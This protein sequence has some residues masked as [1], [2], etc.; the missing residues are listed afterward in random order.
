VGI[1]AYLARLG[2]RCIQRADQ[3]IILTGYS[4]LNKLLGREVYSSQMQL[5]GPKIMGVNGVTHLIVGDD[6][7]GVVSILK[8]LSYVPP[9]VGGPLPTMEPVDPPQRAVEYNPETSCDPR[10][11]ICGLDNGG[12]KW[13][14]GIFD[15]GSFTETLE[16]WA[17]TV[18][19]G[20]ARLGG[21]P[22]AVIAVE[23][24]T[25][26]QTIPADPGQLDS[27]ERVVPQA[28]QVWF[29]DSATKTAQAL[30]DFNKEGLPVFIM[31]N[32]RGFSGG[33]RD[34]FE[35]ILQAGSNIVEN[36]RTYEH[37][38]FVYLP[39][40]G[41]LRG[42]AW[43]V[44]DSKINPDEV[45]MYAERTAKGGVLEPEGLIEIK[46][47]TK[48]LLDCM[49]R[50]DAQLVELKASLQRAPPES[51]S[52]IQKQIQAREKQLLPA[53]KQVAIRFA[54]LHDTSTRLEAKGIIKKVVDWADSRAYFYKRL[55]RRV[56]EE[57][58]IK[59]ARE[60]AGGFLSRSAAPDLIK[61][62]FLSSKP[63][64]QTDPD[65]LWKDDD[66]FYAWLNDAQTLAVHL[67]KLKADRITNQFLSFSARADD[68]QAL[69]RALETLLQKVC[70]ICLT[71]ISRD[72][73]HMILLGFSFPFPVL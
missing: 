45:E 7:E 26:M 67:E 35:G 3:P 8:W 2:I 21:I 49:H 70:V 51:A 40:T 68:L 9:H 58:L 69:P 37:P 15:K 32:W 41:E 57:Q 27:H 63:Q 59:D 19:T 17:K 43:V 62:W 24:Q 14:S 23:T 39:K 71:F 34:L 16:G 48:E 4:A 66:S 31:A 1:G 60:A 73:P 53:Y 52:A 12:G 44:V 46:F 10:A 13:L 30:L 42:G 36:L 33:Q 65:A 25:V 5:G 18:V 56:A 38:V 72:P 22:V 54:E 28:G 20:R 55:K 11:A 50:L 61:H 64:P 29:P 47:R 6:L